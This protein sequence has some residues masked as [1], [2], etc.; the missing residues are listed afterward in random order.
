MIKLSVTILY[1]YDFFLILKGFYPVKSSCA[2]VPIAHVSIL[3][4]YDF[5]LSS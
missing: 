4:L 5:P 2:K 1:I 3:S